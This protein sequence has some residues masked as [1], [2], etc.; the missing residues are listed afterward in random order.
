MQKILL[1]IIALAALAWGGLF[2][3]G[4]AV[5]VGQHKNEGG[6]AAG[7]LS[8]VTC[9]YFDGIGFHELEQAYSP[10]PSLNELAGTG[11]SC[12]RLVDTS[13]EI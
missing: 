12:P 10:L 1:A 13:G 11:P 3:S 4:N 7:L 9:T 2:F 6:G 8:S 5:L